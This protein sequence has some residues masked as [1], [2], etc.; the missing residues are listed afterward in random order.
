[1]FF[2][3]CDT[4]WLKLNLLGRE[5]FRKGLQK[6]SR[7]SAKSKKAVAY[8]KEKPIIPAIYWNQVFF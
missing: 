6:I 8:S 4:H 1:M 2:N 5:F 3:G 7:F